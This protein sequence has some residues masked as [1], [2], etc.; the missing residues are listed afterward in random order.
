MEHTDFEDSG[1]VLHEWM[2]ETDAKSA[3]LKRL[4]LKL[5]TAGLSGVFLPVFSLG[6]GVLFIVDTA[7]RLKTLCR[8][9]EAMLRALQHGLPYALWE[10]LLAPIRDALAAAGGAAG[11]MLK[12]NDEEPDVRLVVGDLETFEDLVR[13][14][15]DEH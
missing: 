1:A 14:L 7:A 6:P 9:P 8:S 12:L 5:H 11:A 10:P 15:G 2:Q 13:T 4:A 3:E